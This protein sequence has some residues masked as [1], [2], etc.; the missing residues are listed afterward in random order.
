MLLLNGQTDFFGLDIGTTALRAVEMHGIGQTKSLRSFAE[1]AISGNIA[2]SDAK[3]D[4]QELTKLIKDFIQKA[5]FST[6]NVAVNLPSNRVFTTVVDMD[7]LPEKELDK[8][9]YYQADA[10]IPTAPN[11]SKIDWAVIGDSPKDP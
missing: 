6:R 4:Q 10:Y 2:I 3:A 5:D 11:E 9:I 7:R 1:T 8:A